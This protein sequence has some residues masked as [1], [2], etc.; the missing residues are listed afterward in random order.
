MKYYDIPGWFNGHEEYDKAVDYCPT[1]GKILEIGCFYGRSTHYM[2]TNIVDTWRTD[3]KVYA[4]DTFRGSSE[5]GFI[6]SAIGEDGTFKKYTEANLQDFIKMK[7]LELIESRSDD[8]E[9]INR[10]EDE[11]FDVIIVDGAHEYE[12]VREDIENWWPKL[13]KSGIMLFDD[14]YME[15]VSQGVAKGLQNKVP[16]Y[17][18]LQGREAY[19]IAYKNDDQSNVKKYHKLVPEDHFK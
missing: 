10:F 18:V 2:C 8:P 6:R 12:A 14:M 4:L 3:I 5:H 19:G 1:N 11:F 15:S 9:T 16:N 13:K 7:F 17:S